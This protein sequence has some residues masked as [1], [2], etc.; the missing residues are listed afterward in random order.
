MMVEDFSFT[1]VLSGAGI[2]P[3]I[4]W[5]DIAMIFYAI[6]TVYAVN[7]L[8]NTA[9]PRTQPTACRDATFSSRI[10]DLRMRVKALP[11][12]GYVDEAFTLCSMDRSWCPLLRNACMRFTL[13]IQGSQLIIYLRQSTMS[14]SLLAPFLTRI[15]SCSARVRQD[16]YD[17]VQQIGGIVFPP[18]LTLALSFLH[19]LSRSKWDTKGMGLRSLLSCWC[20][21]TKSYGYKP[22]GCDVMEGQLLD[23][24]LMS[25][26]FPLSVGIGLSAL[27]SM[28]DAKSKLLRMCVPLIIFDVRVRLNNGLKIALETG[29]RK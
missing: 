24:N 20:G 9:S 6:P 5:G 22:L 17:R 15:V 3:V 12:E 19:A 7:T 4:A 18:L 26:T 14:R 29:G 11:A 10:A 13:F 2:G 25:Y 1:R 28:T 16:R 21:Y 8:P 27:D 23:E